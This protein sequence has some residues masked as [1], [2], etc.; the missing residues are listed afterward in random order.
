MTSALHARP[1][2]RAF[3]LEDLVTMVRG[4]QIRIPNFQRQFRWRE[5]DVRR[6][7][8]SVAR[9]YPIGSLLLWQRP[10]QA[11]RIMLGAMVVD[12]PRSDRAL[13]VVDGQQRL[14]SLANALTDGVASDSRFSLSFDLP[15]GEFVSTAVKNQRSMA[16]PLPVLFDL[17]R[18]LTWFRDHPEA[19]D[20]YFDVATN[21]AKAIRQYSIPGYVV[22]QD[23]EGVLRDIFDRL[24][25]YG[26]RLTRAEVFTA[27]YPTDSQTR[28]PQNI[29]RIA[30]HLDE[31]LGFGVVDGDTLLRAVLARRGSDVMRDIRIEFD[32]D[33][34]SDCPGEQPEH[35]YDAASEC[36]AAA[37]RFLR[38]S[39]DVPHFAFLPYRYLLVVL[40]RW[41]AHFPEPSERERT[42]LRRW[43]WRAAS[44]GPA[45]FPGSTTGTMRAL[46]ARITPGDRRGSLR[47]LLDAVAAG[48][49]AEPDVRRFH[50]NYAS[51]KVIACAMWARQ[52]RSFRD[53]SIYEG[54]DL[55]Q[56]IEDAQT[57]ARAVIT[58]LGRRN[59][60]PRLVDTAA[61]RLVAPGIEIAP[62]EIDQVL[63]APPF[64]LDP[65]SWAAVCDSHVLG[66][67]ALIHLRAGRF[68]DFLEQREHD[69]RKAVEAFLASRWERAFED[70][71]PLD[72]LIMDDVVDDDDAAAD[73]A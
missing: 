73:H 30:A 53:G 51:G 59:L 38:E 6:L 32:E 57:P 1:S 39:A 61:N 64:D 50:T 58:I 18:L 67:A 31:D 21:A 54:N 66:D 36:L 45:L 8:E 69:L 19:D 46:C 10:A 22:E 33:R 23:N 17:P 24:N 49:L 16:V 15:S 35:A 2:A 44:I 70:T 68:E 40:T 25:N 7:F 20:R 56:V 52:P 72:E 4:G 71:P 29:E 47:A 60:A 5:R 9:G 37:V 11:E 27:L 42:L 63:V 62:G 34:K 48:Q 43:L 13:W 41:F 28:P 12:A 65:V 26:K 3:E 55:T 14:T